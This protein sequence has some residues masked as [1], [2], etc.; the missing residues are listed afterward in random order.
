MCTSTSTPYQCSKIEKI[1][2]K[3]YCKYNAVE[4]SHTFSKEQQN[5][6]TKTHLRCNFIPIQKEEG[7]NTPYTEGTCDIWELINVNFDKGNSG[8]ILTQLLKYGSYFP[9]GEM[10]LDC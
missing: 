10:Q 7:W 1:K 6:T 4:E 9:A 3:R 2:K 8:M 5:I